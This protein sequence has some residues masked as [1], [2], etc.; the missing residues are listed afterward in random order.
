MGNSKPYFVWTYDGVNKIDLAKAVRLTKYRIAEGFYRV[1]AI[2]ADDDAGNSSGLYV[3]E[4]NLSNKEANIYID[5]LT[6]H[7][8]RNMRD[9][10]GRPVITEIVSPEAFHTVLIALSKTMA[11]VILAVK[12]GDI[13][14]GEPDDTT[15][16]LSEK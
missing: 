7:I 6:E 13:V 3:L 10:D 5:N 12:E 14:K 9:T 1:E 11:T 16:T 2:Y 8:T 15:L 4:T